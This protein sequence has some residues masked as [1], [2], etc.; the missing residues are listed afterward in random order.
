MKHTLLLLAFAS[1]AWAQQPPTFLNKT[2]T[3]WRKELQ[4]ADPKI[5][6][7]AAFSLGKLGGASSTAVPALIAK[8][9]DGKPQVR[10]AAAFAL[11]NI[12]RDS[13]AVRADQTLLKA[14]QDALGNPE[15]LVR[16]SAVYALGCLGDRATPALKHLSAALKDT[17]PAV[18]QNVAWALGRINAKEI[19]PPL[20]EALR[21]RDPQVRR[22]AAVSIAELSEDAIRTVLYDLLRACQDI[23]GVP[24]EIMAEIRKP[25]LR[26]LAKTLGGNDQNAVA[27]LVPLL[28][29]S[30]AE[31][32][33]ATALILA[34]MGG[35][36]TASS[37]PVL[38]AVLRGKSDAASRGQAAAALGNIGKHASDT[39]PDLVHALSDGEPQVRRFAALG[40]GNMG[41]HAAPA[42]PKLIEVVANTN[43]RADVR[44]EAATSLNLI[45]PTPEAR[46]G[47]AKLLK[48]LGDVRD[49]AA[50]RERVIW[51]LRVHN[52][53]LV[54]MPN[55]LT[56]FENILV[57]PRQPKVKM[58]YYDSA[59]M[60]GVLKGPKAQRS[61]LDELL[62]FLKDPGTQIFLGRPGIGTRPKEG[63][64]ADL[65][66][67]ET[68]Q[69]D[70]RMMAVQALTQI[71]APVRSRPDII[72][73]L[74]II[75]NDSTVLTKLRDDTKTLLKL[76]AKL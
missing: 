58:L 54:E 38:R 15:P 25:A 40:L 5:Q 64:P 31:V 27:G 66:A 11:G 3:E 1:P 10:E 50:V 71:G 41:K 18:R 4:S 44:R 37:V 35:P 60:L 68:G 7:H 76:L 39:I 57:E 28:K 52:V 2:A 17:D 51:S 45:G 19:V 55:V 26:A 23:Q 22:D 14:L 49:V 12:A 16:R 32:R 47:V 21:D 6:R 30:D 9:A 70:G 20:Q 13:A 33:L 29:N 65:K 67:W 46:K 61:T 43:E 42:V 53:N 8:L 48:V 73:Q 69:G 59:Y 36:D 74:E 62:T 24:P 34:K 63:S 72:Q 56:A 75:A